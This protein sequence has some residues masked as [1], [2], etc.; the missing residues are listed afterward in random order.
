MLADSGAAALV[1]T[2]ILADGLA[3]VLAQTP[4]QHVISVDTLD[5]L[6]ASPFGSM[7]YPDDLE[8]AWRYDRG[9]DDADR[10]VESS[11]R[12]HPGSLAD[13]ECF[14]PI[15]ERFVP[16]GW[17]F[18][19]RGIGVW[20]CRRLRNNYRNNPRSRLCR[21]SAY[22]RRGYIPM[23]SETRLAVG[24]AGRNKCRRGHLAARARQFRRPQARSGARPGQRP[25]QRPRAVAEATEP[26][27]S[28]AV[29]A[30][31]PATSGHG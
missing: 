14:M 29:R 18:P 19:Y 7:S 10:S 12:S 2:S 3:G 31:F 23:E 20:S 5:E 30:G 24:Q 22:F 25:G 26:P 27:Q 9:R 28:Q 6:P 21:R 17:F 1:S 13:P 8:A 4:V 16:Y 11:C 15:P